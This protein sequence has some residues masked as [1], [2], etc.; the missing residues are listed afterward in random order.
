MNKKIIKTIKEIKRFDNVA[1]VTHDKADGD[2]LTSSWLMR[3]ILTMRH[4]ENVHNY[5]H[6]LKKG[7]YAANFDLDKIKPLKSVMPNGYGK[8]THYKYV[9]MVDTNPTQNR[10][11]IMDSLSYDKLL[12]IDHHAHGG[13]T[14]IFTEDICLSTSYL[15]CSE[16]LW[17]LA[18]ELLSDEQVKILLDK[19]H[20]VESTLG[21][22]TDNGNL[23]YNKNYVST[24]RLLANLE[25]LSEVNLTGKMMA[26]KNVKSLKTVE[27]NLI[28]MSETGLNHVP[29]QDYM[30]IESNGWSSELKDIICNIKEVQKV[31]VTY[32]NVTQESLD[33]K[34]YNFEDDAVG[35]FV[36]NNINDFNIRDWL[37][38]GEIAKYCKK[39]AGQSGIAKVWFNSHADAQIVFD[40]FRNLEI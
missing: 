35:V 12:I 9:I 16:L 22:F 11:D 36:R 7:D 28:K 34:I 40:K 20:Y 15:S 27:D 18:F 10:V 14:D 5:V 25:E 3:S 1:I 21:V 32:K 33:S 37:D 19:N 30:H 38:S 31:L 17:E 13:K 23:T 6:S 4:H 24:L 39:V 2:A 26:M 8:D 29:E